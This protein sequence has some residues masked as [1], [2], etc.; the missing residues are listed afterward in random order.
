M[1]WFVP[2]P[3][4]LSKK[5]VGI[6]VFPFGDNTEIISHLYAVCKRY[7]DHFVKI[8]FLFSTHFVFMHIFCHKKT[9]T[10]TNIF[11]VPF[12]HLPLSF[13]IPPQATKK[14]PPEDSGGRKK[15]LMK[16]QLHCQPFSLGLFVVAQVFGLA[17]IDHLAAG[18]DINIVGHG[19]SHIEVL[20]N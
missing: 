2:H 16:L 1:Q 20:L 8:P 5:G 13:P 17:L 15:D 14:R 4:I 19:Q 9:T 7:F 3:F 6:A 10:C 12:H 18:H 11:F